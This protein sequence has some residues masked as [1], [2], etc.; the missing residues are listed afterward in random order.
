[1]REGTYT[2]TRDLNTREDSVEILLPLR[3]PH[4]A[5]SNVWQVTCFLSRDIHEDSNEERSRDVY[6]GDDAMA[7]TVLGKGRMA[8]E[9]TYP[10]RSTTGKPHGSARMR[11]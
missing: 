10:C 3:E 8:A 7:I 2:H 11:G 1:M 9:Y 6:S 5:L 4:A